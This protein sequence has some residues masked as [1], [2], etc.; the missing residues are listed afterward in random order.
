MTRI[1]T[2][3]QEI[4]G[5]GLKGPTPWSYSGGATN[6]PATLFR[7]DEGS[8][9]APLAP[10]ARMA[11]TPT[12]DAR[13]LHVSGP[14]QRACANPASGLHHATG[15][16]K[17]TSGQFVGRLPGPEHVEVSRASH[18]G[19]RAWHAVPRVAEIVFCCDLLLLTAPAYDTVSTWTMRHCDWST[20]RGTKPCLRTGWV[21]K[22]IRS[23]GKEVMSSNRKSSR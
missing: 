20:G 8:Q 14:A 1:S 22:Q 9:K 19:K 4:E 6:P 7:P 12:E 21:D 17:A 13:P 18:A 23:P 5:G 11:P 10:Q 16:A 3:A 15:Q 2:C